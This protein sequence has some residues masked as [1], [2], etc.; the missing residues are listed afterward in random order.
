MVCKGSTRK[1]V[2]IFDMWMAGEWK[3][4]VSNYSKH[5]CGCVS[6]L[7]WKVYIQVSSGQ[8]CLFEFEVSVWVEQVVGR[9]SMH[10]YVSEGEERA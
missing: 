3:K 5:V 1:L 7:T 6:V 8:T 9:S 2:L 10:V 4:G